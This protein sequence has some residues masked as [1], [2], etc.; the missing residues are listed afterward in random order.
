M[1]KFVGNG[2][3]Y[4]NALEY[5]NINKSD[6]QK[7]KCLNG[8]NCIKDKEELKILFKAALEK[9]L[10]DNKIS[11][12]FCVTHDSFI[13]LIE[14]SGFKVKHQINVPCKVNINNLF[15]YWI[16]DDCTACEHRNKCYI[17]NG[18]LPTEERDEYIVLFVRK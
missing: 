11:R 12:F 8:G 4:V 15:K 10:S 6:I 16:C 14:H 9:D 1:K 13:D 5:L 3:Y 7:K 17:C 2:Y 18:N